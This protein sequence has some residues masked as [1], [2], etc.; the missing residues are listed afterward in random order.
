MDELSRLLD[1]GDRLQSHGITM[2]F[3]SDA[4][5]LDSPHGGSPWLLHALMEDDAAGGDEAE[6]RFMAQ[7]VEAFVRAHGGQTPR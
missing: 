4:A 5:T 1:L 6:A 2:R 3:T 7:L